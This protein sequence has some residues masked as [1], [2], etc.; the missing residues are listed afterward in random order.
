MNR[1]QRLHQRLGFA[2][3]IF[4]APPTDKGGVSEKPLS[5]EDKLAAAE[6]TRDEHKTSLDKATK[7]R[8]DLKVER[9]TLQTQ[10]DSLTTTAK[11]S[12]DDL[13]ASQDALT[14]VTGE[15]DT[16]Q[17]AHTATKGELTKA[18]GSITRLET[19]CGIKGVNPNDAP[20]AL[21][22]PAD[23]LTVADFDAKMKAAKT[24]KEQQAVVA[25]M[26]KAHTEGRLS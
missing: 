9:D 15:R 7:E 17:N 6:K 10:F 3:M 20:P 1:T 23:K 11:K 16:E 25:E 19:L 4:H 26:E 24:P 14:V 22:T 13:K 8:D 5:L 2:A 18:K 21:T 12:A